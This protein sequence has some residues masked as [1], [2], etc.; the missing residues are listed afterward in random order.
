MRP[1]TGRFS[2]WLPT[3][4]LGSSLLAA[5]A[6]ADIPLSPQFHFIGDL[7][8]GYYSADRDGSSEQQDRLIA[9]IRGGLKWT[10]SERLAATIRLAGRYATRDNHPHFKFFE[11]IP[12]TDGLRSG[13]STVDELFLRYT[14]TPPPMGGLGRACAD[15]I[16]AC[17]RSGRVA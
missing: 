5:V 11:S 6:F 13:D 8:G 7:R 12:D 2:R 10:P 9:R 4:G 16:R 14:P 17:G 1:R 3:A 15:R